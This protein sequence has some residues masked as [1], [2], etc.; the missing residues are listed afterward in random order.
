VSE[1]VPDVIYGVAVFRTEHSPGEAVPE[2]MGAHV[3]RAP[4][5]LCEV[6]LEV[7]PGCEAFHDVVDGL[8]GEPAALLR[9]EEGLAA[10]LGVAIVEVGPEG[11]LGAEAAAA[12]EGERLGAR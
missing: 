8:P 1:A 10:A 12:V 6:R 9:H 11:L 3:R 5:P 2:R 7:G 4:A